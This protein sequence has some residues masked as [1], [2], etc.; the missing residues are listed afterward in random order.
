[1]ANRTM[2]TNRLV[3]WL[4]ARNRVIEEAVHDLLEWRAGMLRCGERRWRA[5]LLVAEAL[6]RTLLT[7]AVVV[8]IPGVLSA[9][10]RRRCVAAIV[11]ALALVAILLGLGLA[12][13]GPSTSTPGAGSPAHELAR[14]LTV[15]VDV[16]AHRSLVALGLLAL[17]AGAL[18]AA[19]A[20]PSSGG[21]VVPLR[22]ARVTVTI[23]RYRR[24]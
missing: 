13:S 6:V 17:C 12:L 18:A 20:S 2:L 5:N 19:A 7:V 14:R 21:P 11:L 3:R 10:W 4:L 16:H 15:D 1:M 9:V 8:G 22:P 24:A 23:P